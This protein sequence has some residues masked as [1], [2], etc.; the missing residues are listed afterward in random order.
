MNEQHRIVKE[1]H[2][3]RKD[4]RY[5]DEFILKYTPFIVSEVS[6]FLKRAVDKNSDD[7]FSIG[8]IAFYEAVRKYREDKGSF[9]S[10]ASLTIK[11][12]L[13]DHMRRENRH[14]GVLPLHSADD[15]EE[16]LINKLAEKTDT[17]GEYA[18]REATKAEIEELSENLN[19]FGVSLS[20]VADNCPRQSKTFDACKA[21]LSFAK[22]ESSIFDDFLRTKRLPIAKIA[23]G[24]GIDRKT[25]ERHR[26][27]LVAL[28]LIQTNGYEIIRGHI[29]YV[30][31]GG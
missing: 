3:A 7:E 23:K 5:C 31:K 6:E 30:L 10:F 9:F 20:D 4:S 18:L 21:A 1:I 25:L 27:Y 16:P 2:K 14:S 22:S 28:F 19:E 11:S 29:Q 13:I 12:R 26:K 8:M 24:S 17:E 15:D